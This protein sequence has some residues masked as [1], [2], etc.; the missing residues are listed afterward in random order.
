MVGLN[1]LYGVPEIDHH[2]AASAVTESIR[3]LH[4]DS[5]GDRLDWIL[6]NALRALL[7]LPGSTVLDVPRLLV[8]EAFRRGVV[9][10][11]R[12]QAVVSFWVDEFAAYDRA[13]R[14]VA[15]APVQNKVGKLR[16]HPPLRAVLGQAAPRVDLGLVL[17]RSQIVVADLS[18]I[19]TGS[20]N[21][22]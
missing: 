9:A 4:A 18:G 20:A 2:L 22:L 16:A 10:R 19:G 15:V 17:E 12:D 11:V 1:P 6:Y 14:T 5:W 21:L 7:Y 3:A 8:D 13:F